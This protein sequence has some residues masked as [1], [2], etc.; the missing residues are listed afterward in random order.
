M[1]HV[2]DS[3]GPQAWVGGLLYRSN[4]Q[5]E[6]YLQGSGNGQVQAHRLRWKK[7]CP[8]QKSAKRRK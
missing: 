8:E 6:K 1:W 7:I 3:D 4:N 2:W 5:T